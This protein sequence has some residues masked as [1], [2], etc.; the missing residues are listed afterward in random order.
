M[1]D[2]Q[3]SGGS[4]AHP[5]A[6]R[7]DQFICRHPSNAGLEMRTWHK[8]AVADCCRERAIFGDICDGPV[9]DRVVPPDVENRLAG[10]AQIAIL[11]GLQ[12][13]PNV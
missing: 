4:G 3:P 12:S 11:D 7:L 10:R 1:N 6:W 9:D 13:R 5:H 2:E 8:A